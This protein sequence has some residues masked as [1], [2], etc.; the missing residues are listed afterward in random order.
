M[1]RLRG[2]VATLVLAAGVAATGPVLAGRPCVEQP[3]EV[4]AIRQGIEMAQATT[5]A[6]EASGASVVVLARAGQ[7]LGRYGLRW[8]HLG[9]AYRDDSG[10]T[11]AWRVVHKLNRCGTASADLFRQ[12]LG[13]F[14]MD[15]PFRYEA[16]FA[17]PSP[18]L[19]AAL[20]P[21]V[22]DDATLARWHEPRYNMLAY[23]WSQGY[24]QS[25]QWVLELIAAAMQPG[26][27]GRGQAQRW[28]QAQ[29]YEPTV[30][31]L[32]TVTRLGAR[33]GMAHVAFD[34]HPPGKRFAGRIETVTVDSMFRWLAVTGLAGPP[35]V[36][37]P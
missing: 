1:N 19:Q 7:D 16:A 37:L 24:Q 29:G 36:V 35:R 28:L 3:I 30:L 26:T 32:D 6:L 10:G 21:L 9:L 23:P 11:P 27:S 17:V 12:G 33:V 25:N 18:E 31:Q 15:R 4:D 13:Q 5:A 20:A 34:D 8:S 2:W 22:R 14:F